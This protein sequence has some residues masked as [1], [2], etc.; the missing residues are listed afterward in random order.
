[1]TDSARSDL[2]ALLDLLRDLDRVLHPLAD[3]EGD[4]PY[5]I[6]PSA[7]PPL[8]PS[9]G[10]GREL[11]DLH[12][13]PS[14]SARQR[15]TRP[16]STARPPS[17]AMPSSF[18]APA[19]A[20]PPRCEL[21]PAPPA[22][23]P[24][25]PSLQP[26][27]PPPEAVPSRAATLAGP[28]LAAP[29]EAAS[30]APPPAPHEPPSQALPAQPSR[31]QPLSASPLP[32]RLP[33]PA[34][35]P[36]PRAEPQRAA[37]R[38]LG[39]STPASPERTPLSM[40]EPAS[41]RPAAVGTERSL[42]TPTAASRAIAGGLSSDGESPA[43]P[44][45]AATPMPNPPL[46]RD[47]TAAPS[48]ATSSPRAPASLQPAAPPLLDRWA[49]RLPRGGAQQQSHAPAP[50][51]RVVAAPADETPARP[52]PAEPSEAASDAAAIEAPVYLVAAPAARHAR[53][54]ARSLSLDPV[55][56]ERA[57][58]QLQRRFRDRARFRVR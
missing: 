2:Y 1:M 37:R 49:S 53:F 33:P 11:E 16:L 41:A 28:S 25:V 50:P 17:N 55:S 8:P 19:P 32:P 13:S 22:A 38:A 6:D 26:L 29:P 54:G 9:T 20:H 43:A 10:G 58:R 40:P 12:A 18:G 5:G 51:L 14:A 48:P 44:R 21:G 7:P 15:E 4:N 24:H 30:A 46:P 35:R 52:E 34:P 45:R 56:A 23:R 36:L 27:Q 39:D 47:P 3:V 57:E 31:S 42:T